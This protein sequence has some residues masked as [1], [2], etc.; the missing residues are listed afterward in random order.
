MSN[1]F[2]GYNNPDA[3]DGISVK[4]PFGL[5]LPLELKIK[6]ADGIKD[7]S[8]FF[9]NNRPK[10]LFIGYYNCPMLCN[11]VR[12]NFFSQVS[13]TN[14]DVGVDFDIIML[15]IS[16]QETYVD[17]DLNEKLY[18]NRYYKNNNSNNVQNSF[19]FLIADEQDM[20]DLTN[21]IGFEYRYDKKSGEYFHPAFVYIVSDKGLIT[22]GL[23]FGSIGPDFKDK[24]LSANMNVSRMNFDDFYTFTCLQADIENKNPQRAFNFLRYA[25]LFFVS[26][27]FFGVGF[28][29]LQNKNKK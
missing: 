28:N 15:S 9:G 21:D 3:F 11:S 10:I 29:I 18:F 26:F 6:H 13:K 20:I 14:Y 5:Q 24:L 7:F 27:M 17:A 19:N 8:S 16:P 25:S 1:E 2:G 4:N 23:Q 12:D 22:D